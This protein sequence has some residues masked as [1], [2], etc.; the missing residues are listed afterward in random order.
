MTKE[1][2]ILSEIEMGLASMSEKE[3]KVFLKECG[4]VLESDLKPFKEVKGKPKLCV[5]NGN[6]ILTGRKLKKSYN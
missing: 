6:T 2:K 4:F 3:R 1:E 5:S